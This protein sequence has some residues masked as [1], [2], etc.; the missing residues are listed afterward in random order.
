VSLESGGR[1]GLNIV[2]EQSVGRGLAPGSVQ[3]ED[4]AMTAVFVAVAWLE[5]NDMESESRNAAYHLPFG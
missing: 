4:Q 3:L 2:E 5:K 1:A